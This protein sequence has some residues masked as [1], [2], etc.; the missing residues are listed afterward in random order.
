MRIL[1]TVVAALAIS[2][3]A[4]APANACSWGKTAK[5]KTEM[6]VADTTLVPQVDTDVSIAT[7]DLSDETIR[8]MTV[9][10]LP[11]EKPAE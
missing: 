10:P 4:F 8:E 1:S 11:A 2:A 3:F 5:A 7:N 6:T 9:L